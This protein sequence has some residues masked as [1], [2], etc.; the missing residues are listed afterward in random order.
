MNQ[1]NAD[2]MSVKDTLAMFTL[3]S[4]LAIFVISTVIFGLSLYSFLKNR[5][6]RQFKLSEPQVHI[7][8]KD[9]DVKPKLNRK[10]LEVMD[11]G[12]SILMPVKNRKTKDKTISP[13]KKK[14]EGHLNRPAL[15]ERL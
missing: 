13:K 12:R 11:P 15:R 14:H 1:A 2:Y 8:Y 5:R 10:V 9:R 7:Y 6:L 3:Y 4:T